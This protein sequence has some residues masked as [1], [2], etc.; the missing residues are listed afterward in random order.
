MWQTEASFFR[1]YN[2]A[3]YLLQ[4][5]GKSGLLFPEEAVNSHSPLTAIYKNSNKV[6]GVFIN[7]ILFGESGAD[8][9]RFNICFIFLLGTQTVYNPHQMAP[10]YYQQLYG[11]SS[12]GVA[13]PYHYAHGRVFQPPNR[14]VSQPLPSYTIL[15]R[16]HSRRGKPASPLLHITPTPSHLTHTLFRGNPFLCM[17]IFQTFSEIYMLSGYV[18]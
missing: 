14:I 13:S 16:R 6:A 2:F 10:Q 1:W 7:P 9:A 5:E 11:T 18:C 3:P 12:S 8:T 17:V 15:R 4:Q